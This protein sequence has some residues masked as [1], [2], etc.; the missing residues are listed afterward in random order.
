ML[1]LAFVVAWFDARP[2][3][4]QDPPLS[5]ETGSTLF[6]PTR[7]DSAAEANDR[8]RIPLLSPGR[9]S[10]A[11]TL[12]ADLR[13]RAREQFELARSLESQ[14]TD[15]AAIVAYR[16][17]LR[18]DP[19]IPEANFR[20]GMLFVKRGELNLG[21]QNFAEEL[22]LAPGHRDAQRQLGLTLARTGASEDGV[23]M[24]EGLLSRDPNDAE[25]WHAL[26][27]AQQAAQQPAAAE[28]SLR[29]AIAL[30]AKGGEAHR[31]LGAVLA[32]VG[33][34]R[35]ARAE[36]ARAIA[37]SPHDPSVWFNLGNL[38]RRASHSDSA[39]AA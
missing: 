29:R 10:F 2:A 9:S 12:R 35:E 21:L 11:D 20:L 39:L 8:E 27:F 1:L 13:R 4:P 34:D 22:T 26:G 37:I 25:S 23:R 28:R 31:D 36:Y 15:V 6:L 17:A 38:E 32:A 33:R 5:T 7:F 16:N 14:G 19:T 3:R 30:G 18:F 24:L